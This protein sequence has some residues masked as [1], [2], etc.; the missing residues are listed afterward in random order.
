M[1]RTRPIPATFAGLFGLVAAF[2][3]VHGCDDPGTLQA[4]RIDSAVVRSSSVQPDPDRTW[5]YDLADVRP[6]SVLTVL[7]QAGLPLEV[8]WRPLDY[9]CEDPRGGR[10]TVQLTRPDAR[11]AEHG[12]VA[13]TG[14]LVCSEELVRYVVSWVEG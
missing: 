10:L 4:I 9:R 12:F 6:D 2:A 13:G 11:M 14:R 5:E 3:S 1:S 8:A 7:W